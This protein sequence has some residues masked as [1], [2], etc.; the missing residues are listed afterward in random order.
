MAILLKKVNFSIGQCGEASRFRVCYQR[1]L[2]RLV[3][4]AYKPK[5][6]ISDHENMLD[7]KVG[8]SINTYLKILE[9]K[10]VILDNE[11]EEIKLCI[12]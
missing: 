2:P 12:F 11:E 6:K 3:F 1:G 5:G 7:T 4:K 10:F 8:N 9:I